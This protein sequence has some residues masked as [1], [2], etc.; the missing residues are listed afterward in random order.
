[1]WGSARECYK[2]LA[3]NYTDPRVYP[4]ARWVLKI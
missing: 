2:D 3:I 1:M 4:E